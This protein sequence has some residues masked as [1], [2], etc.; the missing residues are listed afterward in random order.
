[1]ANVTTTVL[2]IMNGSCRNRCRKRPRLSRIRPTL[3]ATWATRA[4][5]FT[6]LT[7]AKLSS[8]TRLNRVRCREAEQFIVVPVEKH[9]VARS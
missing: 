3:S 6:A 4:S 2:I 9:R 1:M 7:L 5:A 8:R